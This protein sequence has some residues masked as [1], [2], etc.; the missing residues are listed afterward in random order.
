MHVFRAPVGGLFRHVEDLTRAQIA[1]GH[2]VGIFCDSST[3]GPRGEGILASLAPLLALGLSRR[4][5][6]RNP[7]MTDLGA[8]VSLMRLTRAI[9]P[10]VVHAHG[11]KGGVYGRLPAFVG[12]HAAVRAYTPHGGSLNHQPGTALHWVYMRIERLLERATDILTFE[13]E[14]I[15]DR[16]AAF[17]GQPRSLYRVIWNG[18]YPQEFEPVT[19]CPD[20][21]CLVYI[22]EFRAAKGL[23]T[24][25]DALCLLRGRNRTVSVTFIGSGPDEKEL[26]SR[27]EAEG[28]LDDASIL[29]PQAAREA[30]RHGRVMVVPSRA[31]SL[32]YVILEAAAARIPLIAT[33][34]GGVPEIFGPFASKLLPHDDPEA[35]AQA[36]EARLDAPARALA[37]EAAALAGF[38]RERFSVAAMA[39]GVIGAYHQ[40]IA[41]RQRS[42]FKASG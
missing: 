32:P 6:R 13:S 28:L 41:A 23:P 20:A 26:R 25:I 36:I 42:V 11:S 24:L 38:V 2:D 17:V 5:M 21:T 4:P 27:L 7:H 34:V 18:L 15:A 8:I 16:Y 29:P 9:K 39:E 1:R 33:K 37:D 22:G 40:A 10:D 30:M 35:L 14:F 12:R 31:E 3:G 19:P